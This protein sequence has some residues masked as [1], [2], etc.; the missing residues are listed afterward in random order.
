LDGIHDYFILFL[1]SVSCFIDTNLYLFPLLGLWGVS[2]I[3]Q[4]IH[5]ALSPGWLTAPG[6]GRSGQDGLVLEI[7]VYL[8]DG[9]R[10]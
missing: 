8:D 7:E 6:F 2:I 4:L 5:R 10:L 1:F 3:R 9:M